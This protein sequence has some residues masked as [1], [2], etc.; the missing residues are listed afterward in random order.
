MPD[1]VTA[2]ALSNQKIGWNIMPDVENPPRPSDIYY[3]SVKEILR[4]TVE[5]VEAEYGVQIF[6]EPQ[7]IARSL[8]KTSP[9]ISQLEAEIKS[10]SRGVAYLYK[11]KL[12]NALKRELESKADQCFKDFYARIRKHVDNIVV[13]KL[14]PGDQYTQMIMNISCLLTRGKSAELGEEL[15]KINSMDGFSVRFTGP[16][17][18]YSFVSA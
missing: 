5:A 10:Q 13:E 17:P 4:S 14:K 6:W 9:E 15:H 2:E 3:D 7:V 8:A 16:W 12:E 18:P 11:Q 1:W